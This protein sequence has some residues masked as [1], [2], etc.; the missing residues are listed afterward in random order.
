MESAFASSATSDSNGLATVTT[1][2]FARDVVDHNR[3]S[4]HEHTRPRQTAQDHRKCRLKTPLRSMKN[5]FL[6]VW[7]LLDVDAGREILLPCARGR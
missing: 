5:S 2:P 7:Q 1:R 4:Q 3:G 6:I